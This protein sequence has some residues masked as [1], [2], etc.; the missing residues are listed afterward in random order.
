MPSMLQGHLKARPELQPRLALATAGISQ[1]AAER[2]CGA[3]AVSTHLVLLNQR[4]QAAIAPTLLEPD[5]LAGTNIISL[6]PPIVFQ[7][8]ETITVGTEPQRNPLPLAIRFRKRDRHIGP[9]LHSLGCG[10][11]TA[12]YVRVG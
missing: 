7:G 8:L 9:T 2:V 4:L 3:K 12:E 6:F 11:P 5:L 10:F 1:S